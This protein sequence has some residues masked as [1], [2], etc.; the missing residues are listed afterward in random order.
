[1]YTCGGTLLL[2]PSPPVLPQLSELLPAGCHGDC[3]RMAQLVFA[4]RFW[5]FVNEPSEIWANQ[6][7]STIQAFNFAE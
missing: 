7:F 5:F 3:S 2:V 4:I 6:L 1:M